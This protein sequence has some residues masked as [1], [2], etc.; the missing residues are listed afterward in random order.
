MAQDSQVAQ[1]TPLVNIQEEPIEGATLMDVLDNYRS[2]RP[3]EHRKGVI[4]WSPG[5]F[6]P[7]ITVMTHQE[8]RRRCFEKC[9]LRLEMLPF[10]LEIAQILCQRFCFFES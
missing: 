10:F 3:T 8:A 6:Y 7:F 5:T 9:W 2:Q 4:R 1:R